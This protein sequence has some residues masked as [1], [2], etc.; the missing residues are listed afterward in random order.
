MVLSGARHRA[1]DYIEGLDILASMRLCANVP[2][3]HAVQTALGGTQSI[4]ALVAP[5][6]RLHEQRDQ[7]HALLDAI[8]GVSC[9]RPKGRAVPVPENSDTERFGIVDGRAVRPRPAAEGEAARRAGH[10]VSLARNRTTSGS[11]S[12]PTRTN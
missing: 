7:A 5:G 8:E 4:E 9:V 11:C 1:L 10:G 6:G 12:C 2:T 3:Q